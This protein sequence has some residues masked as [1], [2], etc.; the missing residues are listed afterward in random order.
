LPFFQLAKNGISLPAPGNIE[1]IRWQDGTD[2]RILLH[3]RRTAR[4]CSGICL[5]ALPQPLDQT[6]RIM[7]LTNHTE[8]YSKRRQ[9][10]VGTLKIVIWGIAPGFGPLPNALKAMV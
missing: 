5:Q 9:V 1:P 10:T 7:N 2:I 8:A 6:L 3:F 4:F